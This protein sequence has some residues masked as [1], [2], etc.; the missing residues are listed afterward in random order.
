M[1]I[2]PCCVAA[3][4]RP[5][6]SSAPQ[7]YLPWVLKT[8]AAVL[9]L[10]GCLAGVLQADDRLDVDVLKRV[11][12][13]T[14]YLRVTLPDAKEVQG[15]GFFGLEANLVL[16]NAHV[17]GMLRPESQHPKRVEVVINSGERDEQKI[18]GQ[19]LGVDR[20]TDLALIRVKGKDLPEPLKLGTAK[21]LNETDPV[22]IFGYPFGDQLGKNVTVSKS[23]V[24]SLRKDGGTLRQVQVN[25]GMHPG[26]SGG[27]VTDGKG[28][29]VGVAVSGIRNT[30]IN[31]AV[32]ADAV[33]SFVRGHPHML[34]G[35]VVYKDGDKVKQPVGVHMIDPLGRVRAVWYETWTG[36]P[37]KERRDKDRQPGDSERDKVMLAYKDGVAQGELTIPRPPAGK[38]FWTQVM[39][40]N[41]AGQLAWMPAR[42][43]NT[44][45]PV[46]RKPAVLAHKHPGTDT[47]W[48]LT[49]TA[50]LKVRDEDDVDHA[51]AVSLNALFQTTAAKK[52]DNGDKAT[53]DLKI[54][55]LEVSATLDKKA[56]GD[57]KGDDELAK[58][59][60]LVAATLQVGPDGNVL[61]S[62]ADLKRLPKTAQKRWKALSDRIL[63]A[64][65]AATLALPNAEATTG[66]PWKGK[67]TLPVATIGPAEPAQ[68]DITY[69]YL[70]TRLSAGREVAIISFA[71]DVTPK[72]KGPYASGRIKGEA[73]IDLATGQVTACV[74]TVDLD[75]SIPI[76]GRIERASGT[77]EMR[78]D[79]SLP[80]K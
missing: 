8:V 55:K 64:L 61:G 5:G 46:E 42:V 14:V 43:T 78:L 59:A 41:G 51:L 23:S 37:G 7:C 13:A 33:H 69:T 35:G 79:R 10:A 4:P 40:T 19:V 12:R 25:G 18:V 68:A 60:Q 65:D 32:P 6:V 52:V 66:K 70:G 75:L 72:A 21:D 50:T 67:R 30:T 71:G 74:S 31:F 34:T 56:I 53:I 49:T 39:F 28:Q 58:E 47:Q 24:S 57:T 80:G 38:V 77:L 44:L 2:A 76:D 36:D 17:L 9:G 27:P 16:T 45:P 15:S 73:A 26:N 62:S 63:Q 48:K 1:T 3:Y 11:K 54:S 22:F 20:A 29:V